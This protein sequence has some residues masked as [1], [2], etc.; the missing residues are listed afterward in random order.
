MDEQVDKCALVGVGKPGEQ[1][2]VLVVQPIDLTIGG[3]TNRAKE[4][5]A[6]LRDRAA[7]NP[8]TQ[9][10]DRFVI[11]DQPLPVDIRHNSKIFREKLAAELNGDIQ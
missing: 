1:T 10:I 7:R 9:R 2:P 8:L 5:E 6:R 11:R 3:D 4:L